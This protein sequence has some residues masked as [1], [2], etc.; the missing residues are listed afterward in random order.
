MPTS[1]INLKFDLEDVMLIP[2]K[3]FDILFI[4]VEGFRRRSVYGLKL[5]EESVSN[6]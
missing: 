1:V 2:A 4:S 6:L 3:D 5:A